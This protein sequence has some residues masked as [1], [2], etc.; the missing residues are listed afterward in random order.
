MGK[1]VTGSGNEREKKDQNVKKD[2]R[3]DGIQHR[4]GEEK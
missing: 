3:G 1:G 4:P 2:R